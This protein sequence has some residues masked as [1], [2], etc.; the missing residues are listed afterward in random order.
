[1]FALRHHLPKLV[2]PALRRCVR[3]E[4]TYPPPSPPKQPNPH[5][6]FYKEFGRPTA[7]CFL[8]AVLTY[9]LLYISW[10]K[11]ESIEIKREKTN[12]IR[13]LEIES[14]PLE[15][16]P[17]LT[18]FVGLTCEKKAS[19]YLPGRVTLIGRCVSQPCMGTAAVSRASVSMRT[20]DDIVTVDSEVILFS[21]D[22]P[23]V[24]ALFSSSHKAQIAKLH[25]ASSGFDV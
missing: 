10:T 9:Q 11:L 1:M 13:E 5:G 20:K 21:I 24:I 2:R 3:H 7:K 23:D 12:E 4:S 6:N 25:L 8:I 15:E 18:R 19:C 17:R 16:R 22:Q 14:R